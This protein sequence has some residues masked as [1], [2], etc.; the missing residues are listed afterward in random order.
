MSIKK[1]KVLELKVIRIL[2]SNS[3][4][5]L[6]YKQIS[7]KLN[8]K[9][10]KGKE[11]VNKILKKLFK[12]D[13]VYKIKEG[14]YQFKQEESSYEEGI[15]DITKAGNGYLL[16]KD[17]DIF[18]SN[19]KLNKALHNDTVKVYVYKRRNE[20]NKISGEI[21]EIIKRGNQDFVGTVQKRND[22]GFVL[23]RGSKMYTDIFL[24]NSEMKKVRD[25][26]KVIVKIS[27]WPPK[28]QSPFGEIVKTL[29][30]PGM[31]DVEMNSILFEYGFKSSFSNIVHEEVKKIDK[32]I[33]QVE[34]NKRKDFRKKL[35]FTIDPKTAK[36]FD[37]A[38]SFHQK[39]NNNFEVGVHIADVTHY[40][41]ENSNLDKE[42]YS[43]A[44][45]VYLV[46]RVIPMLPEE[47]SNELCSLKPDEEKLT[48]SAV[49]EMDLNGKIY[50]EWYGKTVIKSDNRFSYS[51]V[52]NIIES[53]NN[54]IE[55]EASLNNKE[56][57]VSRKIVDA[58][59]SLDIIAKSLRDKRM[60]KGALSFDKIEVE[61]NLN[62]KNEPVGI[63]LKESK[64]ANKLVEEFML[65]TNRRVAEF[66]NKKDN[67][68]HFVYRVHDNP[69]DEK[70]KN[71][72]E[73]A[74]ALGYGFDKKNNNLNKSLNSLFKQVRG[75]PEQYMIDNLSIRAMSKA[76]YS[77]NNI[78]HYG[79]AFENYTHFTSP[80]RR[81]PDVIAHRLLHKH[82][83][84]IKDINKKVIDEACIHSSFREQKSVK[85]E[86][87]SI[88]Y[89]QVKF[90]EDKVG[91][92]FKGIVSGLT[93]RGV[94]V[95]LSKNKCEGM[96][97]I[98]SI[99]E[100]QYFY[101]EKK[102][103]I[104][105]YVSGNIIKLGDAIQVIVKKA[106]IMNRQLDF[107]LA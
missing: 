41:K 99:E 37:D 80:I 25:G 3:K 74:N 59:T 105:G 27:K 58:I 11:R 39:K 32:S 29:G 73:V 53:K 97:P 90:M 26:D 8:I 10:L 88:K 65:L 7:K 42:A 38:I 45:S 64:D 44:T 9:G 61:F 13:I 55:K 47:L 106:D 70:I 49:F 51:E 52:Q 5:S 92:I 33:T 78:G 1:T 100:D 96:V 102:H 68:K 56:Y 36:D 94:Y 67:K 86:R 66:I 21:V 83:M 30:K 63:I 20:N 23:T 40:L 89:M 16:S 62:K 18:I 24:P 15:L 17:E 57:T 71:L 19:K 22:F 50:K 48:F 95:E 104:Q 98:K 43:R 76:V 34:I 77:T 107:N 85:A 46:D 82:L 4:E 2:R 14:K 69:D 91:K 54:R 81:Y 93:E 75:K 72:Q 31:I 35:T 28:S 60:R 87:D 6:N 12:N 103:Q 79:L 84:G 101:D